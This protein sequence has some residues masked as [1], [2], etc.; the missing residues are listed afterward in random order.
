M[1]RWK[2]LILAGAAAGLI[3]GQVASPADPTQAAEESLQLGRDADAQKQFPAALA[4]CDQPHRAELPAILNGL[5][6]L[7]YELGRYR[8]AESVLLRAVEIL[9]RAEGH[10]R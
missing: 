9:R 10:N 3:R 1:T 7:Y 6:G 4:R 8:E 5:A 2:K